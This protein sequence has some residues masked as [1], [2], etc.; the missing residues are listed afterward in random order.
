MNAKTENTAYLLDKKKLQ[1]LNRSVDEE[2]L[3]APVVQEFKLEHIDPQ[4]R[5]LGR[6][7]MSLRGR[8][9]MACANHWALPEKR[10][11]TGVSIS[12]CYARGLS[13]ELC[14]IGAPR[15]ARLIYYD[16]WRRIW[17]LG[18]HWMRPNA[19][20]AI[21]RVGYAVS[22]TI[23]SLSL[24]LR[25]VFDCVVASQTVNWAERAATF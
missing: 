14:M 25:D 18:C 3:N 4:A 5:C 9:P 12:A 2:V 17:M 20:A 24:P 1:L 16:S 23:R 11:D 22:C 8:R 6:R 19:R 7:K 10:R 13:W 21:R 15:T